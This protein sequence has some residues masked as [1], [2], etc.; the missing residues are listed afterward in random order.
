MS[1]L[2]VW[3]NRCEQ[4]ANTKASNALNVPNRSLWAFLSTDVRTQGAPK[5]IM[6]HHLMTA[7]YQVLSNDSEYCVLTVAISAAS[8]KVVWRLIKRLMLLGYYV[9]L[10]PIRAG[11]VE[12]I[13]AGGAPI[14]CRRGGYINSRCWDCSC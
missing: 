14:L 4:Y 9:T 5:A 3:V 1:L 6:A 13:T 7:V 12:R 2:S 11:N 10:D 8:P